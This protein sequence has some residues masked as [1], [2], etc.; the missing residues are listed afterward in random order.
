[1]MDYISYWGIVIHSGI[2][3][4]SRMITSLLCGTNNYADTCLTSFL[5]GVKE[6]GLPARVRGDKGAENNYI[7]QYM[8]QKQGY[9]GAYIQGLSVHN[10]CIERLH[11]DT[12]RCVLS[13]FIDI[14]LYMEEHELLD[15]ANKVDIYALQFMFVPRIQKSLNEFKERWNHH[16]LLAEQNKSPYQIWILGMMDSSKE[17]QRSLRMYLESA[18]NSNEFFGVEPSPSLRIMP[19]DSFVEVHDVSLDSDTDAIQTT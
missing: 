3:G 6:Y 11:Y 13:H 9:K 8:Q 5:S 12:T 10:Q 18:F 16:Q 1:M 2:D 14:F 15:R 4:F 17:K 7:L 19:P